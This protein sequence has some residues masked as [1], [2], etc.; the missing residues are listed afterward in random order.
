MKICSL[1][2]NLY[3]LLMDMLDERG[4]NDEFAN[5]LVDFSSSYEHSKY[6]EFLKNLKSFA[7]K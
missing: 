1:F 6:V 7:E 3:D 2:Q 5:Q 4:I